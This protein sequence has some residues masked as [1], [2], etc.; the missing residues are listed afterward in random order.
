[1]RQLFETGRRL[2]FPLEWFSQPR[3]HISTSLCLAG[4]KAA[5]VI[6]EMLPDRV[7]ILP[8]KT[9]MPLWTLRSFPLSQNFVK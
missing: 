6:A 1:M 2:I 4:G 5:G 9:S 8:G 7:T 3:G